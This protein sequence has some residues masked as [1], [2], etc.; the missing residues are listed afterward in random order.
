M[1][2]YTGDQA[3]GGGGH[4]ELARGGV[5]CCRNH[6]YFLD[7]LGFFVVGVMVVMGLGSDHFDCLHLVVLGQ[8]SDYLWLRLIVVMVVMVVVGGRG[9]DDDLLN[10][11]SY[12]CNEN[13]SLNR[14]NIL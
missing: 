2:S 3:Q 13:L 10:W 8:H 14:L 11:R 6:L 12:F 4:L 9:L 7:H 1:Y 5:L